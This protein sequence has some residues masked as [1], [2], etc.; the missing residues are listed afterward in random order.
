MNGPVA[1]AGSIPLLSKKSGIKLNI[2]KYY[3]NL[4]C[5]RKLLKRIK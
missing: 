4:C 3:A 1:M 5:K 2:L